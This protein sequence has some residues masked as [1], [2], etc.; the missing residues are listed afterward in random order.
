MKIAE[1]T[2][3]PLGT[4]TTSVSTYISEVIKVLE[5]NSDVT[6]QLNPMG[7]VICANDLPTLYKAIEQVQESIFDKGISRVYS[8]IKIDDR[9]DKEASLDQKINSVMSKIKD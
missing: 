5:N 2:I 7:T 6:Y 9:R 8:V 1:L 4:Q 3:L